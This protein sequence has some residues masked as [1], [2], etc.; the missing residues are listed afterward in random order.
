LSGTTA[1]APPAEARAAR[2]PALPL[3][4]AVALGAVAFAPGFRDMVGRWLATDSYYGHGPLVPAVS[5]WLVF[6]DREALAA[7]P[8]RS[9][10]AGLAVLAFAVLLLVAS[11]VEDVHFTQ[12]FALVAAVW[13]AALL[14][15]GGPIV[16]RIRFPLAYLALMVP[17]PQVAIAHIT[18]AL[19]I[20]AAKVA[21]AAIDLAGIPVLLDGST[22]HLPS[23]SL[24]VDDVCSGLRTMI[25]LL[26]LAAIFAYFERSRARAALVVLLAA[27]IA[28]VANVVRILI[29]C[30]LATIGSSAAHE[31]LGHE[32]TGLSVYAVAVVL[33]MAL[34]SI[35]GGAAA[36]AAPAACTKAGAPL[37]HRGPSAVR[38]GLMLGLLGM[39]A[40][41]A[42]AF[43]GPAAASTATARTAA[44]PRRAGTWAGVD[45]P[46]GPRVYDLLETRDVLIRSYLRPGLVA[47]VDLYVVH[48][49]DSRKVAHPPE[50]CFSGGGFDLREETLATL[51]AGALSIPAN[52]MVLD[53]G[54]EAI[55]V[56]YWYRLDGRDTAG[57][58]EHQLAELLRR[59]R[60][61]RHEA[62]MIRL[63]TAIGPD[64]VAGA[65][66]RIAAFAAEALPGI[67]EPLS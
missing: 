3:A 2:F 66:R 54:R 33:L 25:A 46:I 36:P 35:P 8:R 58:I 47:P 32:L 17:L 26:A 53:R 43:S 22:I 14:L 52:R 42:V 45:V 51:R 16:R 4:A 24:T 18:F 23:V 15:F 67:L 21:V 59:L 50:M 6:R 61:E 11:L 39:G 30:W 41:A 19:K 60:R 44:I 37:P 62:S 38:V 48:A 9:S 10:A 64:G 1:L 40:A 5:A 20:L 12:N 27:P 13:G 56:Y 49:A 65:E 29:L 63:T 55:L 28:V 7:I 57:F 31:G 34:R